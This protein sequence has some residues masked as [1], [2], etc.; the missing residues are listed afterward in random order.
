MPTAWSHHATGQATRR[1]RGLRF[2]PADLERKRQSM[3]AAWERWQ[4]DPTPELELAYLRR[5]K[6]WNWCLYGL[7]DQRGPDEVCE[8]LLDRRSYDAR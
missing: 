8:M 4:S 5:E 2:T 3:Y 7:L 1:L 6:V